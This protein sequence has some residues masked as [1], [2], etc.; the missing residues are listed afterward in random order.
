MKPSM[1]LVSKQT[2]T[3]VSSRVLNKK[4][5]T[6]ARNF[7]HLS[8]YERGSIYAL[9]KKGHSQSSIAK[10]LGRRHRSTISREIRR[11]TTTQRTT[12]LTTFK[13]Y[14]PETGQAVYEK[15]R[16]A[17]GKKSKLLQV[18]P[19]LQ[20]AEEKILKEKWS[21][22]IVVGKATQFMDRTSIVCAKTLYNY[23]K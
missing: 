13:M 7:K 14:F 21:P 12:A 11:G 15:S 1:I 16:S 17:C 19:F 8:T 23:I 2:H 9:L 10:E 4:N 20:Y 22:D 3:E 18:E 6:S 5:T